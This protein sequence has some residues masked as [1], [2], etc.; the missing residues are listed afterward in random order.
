MLEKITESVGTIFAMSDQIATAI[1]EQAVVTQ[2]VAENVVTIEQKS[3]ESTEGAN[4]IATTAREQAKLAISLQ[5]MASTFK[6]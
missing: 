5:G 4:Q 6:V 3:M 1:E 2:D